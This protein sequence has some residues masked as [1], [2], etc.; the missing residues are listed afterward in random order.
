MYIK[1]MRL[2]TVL[3]DV[4]T[5]LSGKGSTPS[6]IRVELAK[7]FSVEDIDLPAD[8]I[9]IN[10]SRNGYSVR[11]QYENRAPYVADIWL[12]VAFD[13]QVEIRR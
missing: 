12:V 6:S 9:K 8:N 11:V 5:E 3:D 13:K 10:Q 7:R 4:Q 1:N 2:S